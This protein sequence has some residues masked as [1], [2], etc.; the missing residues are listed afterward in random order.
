M[1]PSIIIAL[2]SIKVRKFCSFFGVVFSN[3]V[4]FVCFGS[5]TD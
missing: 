4:R 1:S 3:S 2:L 5:E